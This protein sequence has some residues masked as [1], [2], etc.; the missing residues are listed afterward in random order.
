MLA[1]TWTMEHLEIWE[2]AARRSSVWLCSA[3]DGVN[4]C[5]DRGILQLGS[6]Y[7]YYYTL[8]GS[9]KVDNILGYI[10]AEWQL[11]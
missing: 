6:Y 10:V 11:C 5:V 8:Q 9:Q 2:I 7:V 4:A 1:R 3:I